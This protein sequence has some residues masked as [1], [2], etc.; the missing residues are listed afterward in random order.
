M[1]EGDNKTIYIPNSKLA[2]DVIVNVSAKPT[3]RVE[4]IMPVA[5]ET[6]TE[7]AMK[8]IKDVCLSNQLILPTPEPFVRIKEFGDSSIDIVCR[9]WV[10]SKDY[11]TVNFFLLSEIKKQFDI[12][13]I[14]IP[15]I[16]SSTFKYLL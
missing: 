8:V 16:N 10:N 11:W 1:V 4:V 3:R 9:V 5:Y 2:N 12:N 6:N 13:N 15:F 7:L 14:T